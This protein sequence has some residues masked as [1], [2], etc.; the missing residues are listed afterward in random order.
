M[1]KFQ[2]GRNILGKKFA[3]T[4]REHN[5]VNEKNGRISV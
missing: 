1:S 5:G 3:N 4:T 2:Y